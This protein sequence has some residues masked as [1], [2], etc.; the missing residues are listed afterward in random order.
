MAGERVPMW[1]LEA[2]DVIRVRHRHDCP[3]GECLTHWEADA[4]VTEA[5]APV[6][7][8][9][10]VKWAGDARLPGSI[11]AV[12]GISVVRLDEQALRMG[13]LPVRSTRR[14]A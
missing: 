10:A 2:G 9:V 14:R 3:S 1:L 7:G 11:P 4:V 6:G 8:R 12:T 13:R 5:P